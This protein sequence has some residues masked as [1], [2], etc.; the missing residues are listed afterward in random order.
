MG[1]ITESGAGLEPSITAEACV[2]VFDDKRRLLLKKQPDSGDWGTIRGSLER[3]E[4]LEEA[5]GREL[6][7]NTGLTAKAF[8]FVGLLS[9]EDTLRSCQDGEESLRM[10]VVFEAMEVETGR[11]PAYEDAGPELRYFSLHEPILDIHPYSE[12]V[13]KKTEYLSRWHPFD[14]YER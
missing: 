3:G 10:T 5:A 13:L 12:R 4:S 6:Y 1:W 11:V 2:L 8:K 14:W 9:E 7:A